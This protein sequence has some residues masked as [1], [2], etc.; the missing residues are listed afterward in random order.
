MNAVK[1]V[2]LNVFNELAG[3]WID[4]AGQKAHVGWQGLPG[5]LVVLSPGAH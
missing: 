4:L 1:I 3:S 2:M 5:D